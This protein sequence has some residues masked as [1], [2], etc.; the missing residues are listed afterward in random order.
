MGM[1]QEL[2]LECI[3]SLAVEQETVTNMAVLHL[4]VQHQ[5]L[6]EILMELMGLQIQV[7]VEAVVVLVIM[8]ETV[9]QEL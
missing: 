5:H 8:L 9:V 4:M 6:V 1:H 3:I 2:L 7:L